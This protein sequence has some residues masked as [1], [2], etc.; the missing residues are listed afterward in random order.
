MTAGA[1]TRVGVTA[2]AVTGAGV[3]VEVDTGVEVTAGA[4][5]GGGLR[6]PSEGI[7]DRALGRGTSSRDSLLLLHLWCDGVAVGA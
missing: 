3:M 6:D 5:T 4:D 2:G 7:E 1:D